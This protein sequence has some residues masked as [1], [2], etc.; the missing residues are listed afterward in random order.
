M[1]ELIGDGLRFSFPEVH[2]TAALR[3]GFQ[4]T[5]RIPDTGKTYPLPPGLGRFPVRHVDD[6]AA[7]V[8]P[9]WSAHGGVMLP[10]YQAEA[11]WIHFE[12]E[13]ME[14]RD[15]GYPFAVKIAA[16]KINAVTGT[17]WSNDLGDEPQDY[18]VAP[19]QPWLDGFAVEKGVIR[20]FVAM[21]LGNG[22]TAEEQITG[23]AEHGGLQIIVY[24]MK[25]DAFERHF[26]RRERLMVEETASI[27][28]IRP[29]RAMATASMGLAPGGRMK[30]E[31]YDD[32]FGIDDCDR[33][34][35]SRWFVHLLNTMVWEAV[36]GAK[37]PAPPPTAA[38]YARHG[39][40]WFEYYSDTPALGGAEA[41]AR[42]KSVI[43][44]AREKG[45]VVLPENED[46]A[47][48][49]VVRLS[50]RRPAEIRDGVF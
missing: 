6:F 27:H 49:H 7:S 41:L 11:L 42:L 16:G 5:L 44:L 35:R 37:P 8:P 10:M 4:R 23:A 43:Q 36:T 46:A 50:D 26:P 28:A 3:I 20:Q 29:T 17:A 45:Q 30:Q 34:S 40:P 39:L 18:L 32:P 47:I 2:P 22:Y 21:P 12:R 48:D 19:P 1:V 24:P 25:R 33:G 15:R 38:Q 31:I 14:E 13:P 9:A